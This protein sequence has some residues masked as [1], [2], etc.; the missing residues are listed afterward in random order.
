MTGNINKGIKTGD[1]QKRGNT[2]VNPMPLHG[3]PFLEQ[4]LQGKRMETDLLE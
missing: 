3:L 1:T 2:E 4:A